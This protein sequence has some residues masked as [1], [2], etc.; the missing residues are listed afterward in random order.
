MIARS[1]LRIVAAALAFGGAAAPAAAV[2]HEFSGSFTAQFVLSNF[3]NT[4]VT[5]NSAYDPDGLPADPGTASFLEQRVRLGYA[6][7]V[8]ESLKLVSRFEI[9][10]AYYGDASYGV[11]ADRGAALGAD[12]VNLETKN[13]YLDYCSPSTGFT[14]RIG[15]QEYLDAFEGALI[16]ADAA[17]LTFARP[18]GAAALSLGLFRLYDTGDIPGERTADL[19]AVDGS[20]QAGAAARVGASY[21]FVSDERGEETVTV[22]TLGVSARGALGPATVNGYLLAQL[23][24]AGGGRDIRAFAGNAGVDL[25]VGPG[26]ARAELNYASGDGDP[27]DGTARHLQTFFNEYW[28]GSH[29]LGLLTRDDYGLTADNGVVYDLAFGGRG[30]MIA[31]A[32]YD[33]PLG[34]QTAVSGNLGAGWAGEDAG[35]AGSSLGTEIN[36]RLTRQIHECL[37]LTV[38]AAYLFLGTFYDGAAENGEDPDNPWD[39]RVILAY[40]F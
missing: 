33:L 24:D 1:T 37:S 29:S 6:A 12:Q 27:D 3:N 31:S 34:G 11:G 36:V 7:K 28:Y 26:T 13:L 32:G 5:K 39:A 14:A 19:L 16:W 30:S 15:M 40:S 2:Q 35:R 10:Y 22:H 23:G 21:Y 20:Y 18:F 25:E 8:D 38:R 4:A 9:D 17:G